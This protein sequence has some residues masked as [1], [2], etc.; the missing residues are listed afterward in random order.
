MRRAINRRDK[1]IYVSAATAWEISIKKTTGKLDAPDDL[2]AVVKVDGFHPLPISLGHALIAGGLPRLH[3]DPFDR[4]L[5]AQA[6]CESLR[7]VTRDQAILQYDVS[8]SLA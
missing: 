5:I 7:L 6:Q 4:M 2:E 1:S 8:V 3:N